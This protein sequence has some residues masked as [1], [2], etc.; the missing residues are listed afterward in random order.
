MALS[1]PYEGERVAKS[2]GQ[3]LPGVEIRLVDDE[4][5][6]RGPNVFREYWG[7]PELTR[8]SFTEDGWFKTGDIARQDERGYFFIQG[9]A[10]Q[11]IIKCGGY[12]LSALEIEGVLLEHEDV[13][14]AAVLGV[15]DDEWGERVAAVLVW[16]TPEPRLDALKEWLRERLAHYKVPTLWRAVES[17]PRNAMGKTT[18]P[19]LR[20]LFVKR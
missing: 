16:K 12:K 4:I 19:A 6:V 13:A 18:K 2:V 9:R 1:N 17:L 5:Q 20:E 11:D 8:E 7:K 15:A 3:P 10:S 14:E